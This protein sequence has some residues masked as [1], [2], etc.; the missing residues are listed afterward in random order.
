MPELY[1][2]SFSW[3]AVDNSIFRPMSKFFQVDSYGEAENVNAFDEVPDSSWFTNRIG[4][5]PLTPDEVASGYCA[6]GPELDVD[7]PDGSWLVDHGKDNG[8][9]PGFRVNVRGQKYL[10]KTDDTQAERATGAAAIA[11]RFYYAAGWWAPCDSVVYFKRSTLKLKPGLTITAN[12]G[13]AKP[14][15][16]KR[17]DGMLAQSGRRGELYRAV[18]SRW[19]PGVPLGPLHLRGQAQ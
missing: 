4:A 11:S 10:L 5:R 16:E 2:S 12:V 18:A 14:F 7:P 17:L 9:N 6:E 15:D 8:A 19:I 13:G 1:E 3:D